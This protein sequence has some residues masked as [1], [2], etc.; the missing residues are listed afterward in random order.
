M[1][2]CLDQRKKSSSG[3]SSFSE[4]KSIKLKT[5]DLRAPNRMQCFNRKFLANAHYVSDLIDVNKNSG[6]I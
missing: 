6:S 4:N 2:R 1:L 3:T 5:Y